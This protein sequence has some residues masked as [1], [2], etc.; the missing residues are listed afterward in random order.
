MSDSYEDMRRKEL[1]V[2]EK[3][4]FA[5]R[6]TAAASVASA[7]AAHQQAA[8]VEQMR[9]QME[10]NAAREAAHQMEMAAQQRQM[11]EEQRLANFRNTV[12][13]TLPLLKSEEEKTQYLTEQLLPKL[14]EKLDIKIYGPFEL[15]CFWFTSESQKVTICLKN[16]AGLDLDR[17]LTDGNNLM[18][19]LEAF[20]AETENRKKQAQELEKTQASLHESIKGFRAEDFQKIGVWALI[21]YLPIAVIGGAISE[22][23]LKPDQSQIGEFDKI[24]WL[25]APLPSVAFGAVT[26]FLR[27]K[28]KIRALKAKILTLTP[29]DDGSGLKKENEQLQKETEL[30]KQQWETY[31][32]KI[33]EFTINKFKDYIN[34]DARAL[35]LERVVTPQL[36]SSLQEVQSFLPPSSRLPAS[37]FA[38]FFFSESDVR[39]C[40]E[41]QLN[42]KKNL[43][44]AIEPF[45]KNK[46][47]VLLL[48]RVRP[49]LVPDEP[50]QS[51]S[52][53]RTV[54]LTSVPSDKK[55]S[56][57]KAIRE[58]KAGLGLAEAKELRKR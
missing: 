10:V 19:R 13:T 50:K 36:E 24:I 27:K 14:N 26:H 54:R 6:V 5:Q 34:C 58:V 52:G 21:F 20:V 8:N 47:V 48:A 53:L 30:Q 57:I 31:K 29:K 44:L 39:K 43:E 2:Q 41:N 45:Y 33:V 15:I 51:D 3:Q 4:L 1:E 56:V 22:V 38:Q 9:R 35:L 55:I 12:L 17:F 28:G 23:V 37:H 42:I 40:E 18:A 16:E 11:A 32:P 46:T 25:I 49:D 7:V